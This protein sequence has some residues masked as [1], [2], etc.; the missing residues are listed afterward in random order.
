MKSIDKE[1]KKTKKK[2]VWRKALKITLITLLSLVLL[3]LIAVGVALYIIFSPQKVTKIVNTYADKFLNADVQFEQVDITFLSTFPDFYLTLNNGSIVSKAFADDAPAFAQKRDTLLCFDICRIQLDPVNYLKKKDLNIEEISFDGV[4]AYAYVT[5]EGSANWD[6]ALPSE[7]DTTESVFA[8]DEY[9]NSINVNKISFRT[10]SVVYEDFSSNVFASLDN[11]RLALSGD[12]Y[13]MKTAVDI[14]AELDGI[15]L[16]TDSIQLANNINIGL[17]TKLLA[18]INS[19]CFDLDS[20]SLYVNENR[21]RMDG[22]VSMPDTNVIDMNIWI[23]G[24]IPALDMLKQMVPTAYLPILSHVDVKGSLDVNTYVTG[25]YTEKSFPVVQA[26][27]VLSNAYLNYDALEFDICDIN[28]LASAFVDLN[29]IKTSHARIDRFSLSSNFLSAELN[30]TANDILNDPFVSAKAKLKANVDK[31]LRYFPVLPAGMNVAGNADIDLNVNTL[32]SSVTN[33]KLERIHA[34]AKVGLHNFSVKSPV[35]TLYANFRNAD[36]S[37]KTNTVAKRVGEKALVEANVSIDSLSLIYAT[38]ANGTV[39]NVR[40]EAQMAPEV[41]NIVTATLARIDISNPNLKLM[42][43][44]D[45]QSKGTTVGLSML[46]SKNNQASPLLT[47]TLNTAQTHILYDSISANLKTADIALSIRPLADLQRPHDSL[48]K[49]DTANINHRRKSIYRQLNTQQTIDYLLASLQ[50]DTTIGDSADVIQTFLTRWNVDTKVNLASVKV[51]TP[52]MNYP[53]RVGKAELTLD[54]RDLKLNDFSVRVR[55]TDLQMSGIVKHVRRSLLGRKKWEGDLVLQSNLLSAND[56]LNLIK[57]SSG[58]DSAIAQ[59]AQ[60]VEDTTKREI[61]VVP[62]NFNIT[63][64]TNLKEVRYDKAVLNDVNGKV[65]LKNSY[66]ILDG[67]NFNSS[68]GNVHTT[69]FY[70]AADK[71]GANVSAD[72]KVDKLNITKLITQI[73]AVDT[74]MPM[75]RSFEGLISADIMALGKLN[76]DF[77]VDIPSLNASCLVRGDSLVLLDNETFRK[78]SKILLFK[79]KERNLVDSLSLEFV[80]KNKVINFFPFVF[81]IDRYKV[82]I[83]GTQYADMTFDYKFCALQWPLK[84]KLLVG[85][86]GDLND[87]DNAKLKIRLDKFKNGYAKEFEKKETF[88]IVR[89]QIQSVLRKGRSDA[90]KE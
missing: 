60:A 89:K 20:A 56:L 59:N 71:S 51:R 53:V 25:T 15:S 61:I 64:Q 85:Y 22:Y 13:K 77:G 49:R 74:L 63:L 33:M 73:P 45:F 11:L 42:E 43:N 46:P 41:R 37:L 76:S 44:I 54:G 6:I 4:T 84:L 34:T 26:S 40:I 78:L 65:V 31:T 7:P 79:N 83:L 75:L 90:M 38:L 8:I 50:P 47:L 88:S 17:K 70:K 39:G 58:S 23:N 29:K 69:L 5:P 12:F 1:I 66:I 32:L 36:I 28:L 62:N 57:S 67:L 48:S 86:K 3:V 18:D 68:L 82:G 16:K 80:M 27:A 52:E 9:V 10:K 87:L 81:S 2:S 30:A 24:Q 21:F 72:L 35:D 19:T 14:S 55:H